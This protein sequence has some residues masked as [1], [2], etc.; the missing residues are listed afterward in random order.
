MK[1]HKMAKAKLFPCVDC[2][3]MLSPTATACGTCNS[4]DPFHR[5]RTAQKTQL[6]VALSFGA[7]VL[8]FFFAVQYKLITFE[9]MKD[10]LG[11][12]QR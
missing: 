2:G 1:S 11:R 6:I 8:A 10:L 3:S 4:T 7:I 9:M 5:A 12:N